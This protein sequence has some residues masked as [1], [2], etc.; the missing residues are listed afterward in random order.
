MS[1]DPSPEAILPSV[2][3]PADAPT[4]GAADPSHAP[5]ARIS[6]P[7]RSRK[8]TVAQLAS[9]IVDEQRGIFVLQALRWAPSIEDAF[10]ASRCRQLPTV[11][12]DYW[13]NVDLGFDPD[14][15]IRAFDAI[16]L[17]A[18][19]ELGAS[20]DLGAALCT[21]AEQ[22]RNVVSM[23]ASRG[24]KE[25]YRWSRELYGSPKDRL[26]DGSVCVRDLGQVA[27]DLLARVGS[28]PLARPQ[29]EDLD[30]EQAAAIL[31][32]RF[33]AFFGGEH[34]EVIVDEDLLADATAGPD[35][36][37]IRKDATFS[38]QDL[39]TLEVHEGW[40]HMATTLNGQAQPVARWLAKG[41]PRTAATQEGLATLV[42]ILSGRCHVRRARKLN[43]R[44]LAV[45]KA[46]D[47][48]SF[49]DVF[50]FYRTEGYSEDDCFSNTRRV[51]RGGVLEGGAPFTKDICYGKGL[52]LNYAFFEQCVASGRLDRIPLLF[53]GKIALEDIPLIERR[54]A[55]GTIVP[56]THLP[57]FIRNMQGVAA[58]FAFSSLLGN[59]MHGVRAHV[60][61]RSSRPRSSS[62]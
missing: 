18:D 37:K 5:S 21:V 20:D 19:R 25:F 26:F 23:L 35:Y 8:E 15:K 36:V 4:A 44:I 16:A 11:D 57:P 34:I 30:A 32:E 51:F 42:E 39:D 40:V 2:A 56:P 33:A 10:F 48:A 7:W 28:S 22:Y 31:R 17:D 41:P 3:P 14:A 49:L 50:E 6:A 12:P 52:A 45:D 55:D 9:R 13:A 60:V 58:S 59:A 54:V 62:E 46:E 1:A 61:T 24:T 47:G 27:Y 43:D 53:V 29:A 38:R